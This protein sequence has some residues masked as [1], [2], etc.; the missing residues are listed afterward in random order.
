MSVEALKKAVEDAALRV[1]AN[2]N[3][4]QVEAGAVMKRSEG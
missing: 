1:D 2:A 4:Y 3:G